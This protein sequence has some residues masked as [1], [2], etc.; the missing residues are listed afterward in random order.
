MENVKENQ[1]VLFQGR[2]KIFL[3]DFKNLQEKHNIGVRP[4][5]TAIGPD[6]QLTDLV[7]PEEKKTEEI[8]KV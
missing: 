8:K 3:E 5:I 2:V 1:E 4:I 7:N 6:L